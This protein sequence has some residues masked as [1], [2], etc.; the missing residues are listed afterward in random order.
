MYMEILLND[1]LVAWLDAH[2]EALDAET[3]G[4]ED[5]LK[6]LAGAGLLRIGVPEECGGSG[7]TTSSA[8]EGVTQLA[9]HS[10]SAVFVFWVQRA[11]IECL[12]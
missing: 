12:L 4:G 5:L 8:I 10:L 11:A 2:A 6:M 3:G 7:G 1:T 9:G